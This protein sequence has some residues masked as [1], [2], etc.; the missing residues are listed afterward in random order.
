VRPHRQHRRR[1]RS[2][3]RPGDLL[4]PVPAVLESRRPEVR[5]A[6]GRLRRR[7]RAARRPRHA[8]DPEPGAADAA[9]LSACSSVSASTRTTRTS[10]A[11]SS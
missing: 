2:R 10:R 4:Q 9:A 5:P 8:D 1:D 7:G 6:K 11:T 3:R